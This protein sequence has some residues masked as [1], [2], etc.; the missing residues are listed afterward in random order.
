MRILRSLIAVGVHNPVLANVLMIS[1]LV[2]GVLAAGKLVRETFPPF[3]IDIV[4]VDVVYPG[5]SPETVEDAIITKLDEALQGIPGVIE[6]SSVA[7]EG[8]GI[9][10]LSL[11]D[12]A[13]AD[14]VIR[15]AK[16]RVDAL[17][18]LPE[19]SE[20]PI[21]R[22]QLVPHRVIN[23]AV[24]GQ[25]PERTLKHVGQ[26]IRDAL[27]SDPDISQVTI[28]GTRDEE[29]VIELSEP[30]MQAY[31]LTFEQVMAAVAQGTVDLPA[32]ILRTTHEEI[33]LRTERRR[34]TAADFEELV[35]LTRP[36]HTIVRL[37]QVATIRESYE[38]TTKLARMDGEPAVL[39]SVFKIESEDTTTIARRVRD[40]IRARQATLPDGLNL[41]IWADT[42]A[43][44]DER[45][46]V[47]ANAGLIGFALVVLTLALF[48]NARLAF[49]VAMGLPLSLAGAVIVMGWWGMSLNLITL[50]ALIMVAG[51]VVDDAIVIGERIHSQAREHDMPG[52]SCAIEGAASVAIPVLGSSATTVA[53]FIPLLFVTGVMGKFFYQMPIVVIAALSA[54]ALEAFGIL[55]AHLRNIGRIRDA[56]PIGRLAS[57]RYRFDAG[58]EAFA[59]GPYRRLCRRVLKSR[60][61]AL[62]CCA[63]VVMAAAGWVFGGH[64]PFI[65]LG[66]LDTDTIRARIRYIE[67]T[68]ATTTEAALQRLTTAAEMLNVDPDVRPATSGLLVQQVFSL[69]GEWTRFFG[70]AGSHVG[71]VTVELMRSEDRRIDARVVLERWQQLAG[72]FPEAVAVSFQTEEL[73]P[74]EKPIEIRLH[75]DDLD[76]LRAAADEVAAQL[77]TYQGLRDIEDDLH[78]GKRELRVRLKP[79]ARNLGLTAADLATQ[80]RHGFLGGEAVRVQRGREEVV[81]RVRYDAAQR[82]SLGQLDRIRLRTAAGQEIPFPEAAEARMVRS[83]AAL[84]HQDSHRRVRVYA[85]LDERDANAERIVDDLTGGFL[86]ELT[87]RYP[88]VSYTIGGQR[89]QIRESIESLSRGILM[90]AVVIYAILAGMMRS[91]LQPIIIT[92]IIPLGLVGVLVGHLLMGY[93]LTMMSVCG[94][95]AL[96]G[97]LVNDSLVLIHFINNRIA[98][99]HPVYEAVAAAGE[100]RFRAVLLTSITTIAGV[101]PLLLAHSTQAKAVVPMAIALAFGLAAA[102]PLTLLVVPALYLAVNDLKRFARWLYRGGAYPDPEGVETSNNR[103]HE[104]A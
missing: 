2:G 27:L 35:V 73:G 14:S 53:A 100:A 32:G 93:E 96:G 1:L 23:V 87:Q 84:W 65:L 48:L 20:R 30:A 50:F 19:E 83:Y 11:R 17:T 102:T 59:R 89:A 26:E 67:G 29:I 21:V 39:V 57:W 66:E 55:P 91:Y 4:T 72:P 38:E 22:E 54:S 79:A 5:A 51:L 64:I 8:V 6:V 9:V 60:G 97:V 101:M 34:T 37:G 16:D 71:E 88:A 24:H 45:L 7:K 31:G 77:A 78:P 103:V 10:Y 80:L 82:L 13:D 33:V 47:L 62:G 46:H 52:A 98:Q 56:K 69:L 76:Q 28:V 75:G 25:V 40:Y 90:A 74:T 99:G 3:S 86:P 63:A 85:D 43:D 70:E 61:L 44:V 15:D 49:W 95:V 18:T 94:S 92:A 104:P 68:P 58:L 81:V 41:S 42:S 36:D 12:G